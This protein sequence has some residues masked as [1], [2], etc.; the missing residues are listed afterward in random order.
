MAIESGRAEAVV[1]PS[2]SPVS[3]GSDSHIVVRRQ[4]V[5]SIQL[6]NRRGRSVVRYVGTH[7]T[8]IFLVARIATSTTPSVGILGNL[9][10]WKVV[11]RKGR[12]LSTSPDIA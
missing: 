3:R 2:V 4:T 1:E 5:C 9:R 11:S 8:L 12:W 6:P 7:E 10:P